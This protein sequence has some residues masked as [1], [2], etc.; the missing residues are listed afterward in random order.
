MGGGGGRLQTE[1]TGA[2][3][4]MWPSLLIRLIIMYIS[5]TMVV[6]LNLGYYLKYSLSHSPFLDWGGGEDAPLHH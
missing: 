2:F 4:L 3:K 5:L 6:M 1:V